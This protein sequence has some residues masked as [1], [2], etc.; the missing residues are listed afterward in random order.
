MYRDMPKKYHNLEGWMRDV[1]RAITDGDQIAYELAEL[2]LEVDDLVD[3]TVPVATGTDDDADESPDD[4][5]GD[6]DGD[7]SVERE[8]D[9]PQPRRHDAR[10]QVLSASSSGMGRQLADVPGR[11]GET[12]E[13]RQLSLRGVP[14]GAPVSGVRAHRET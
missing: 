5:Q 3:P 13:S 14:L 10:S 6:L 1:R 9:A 11:L 7:E 4:N 12:P 2:F 8:A